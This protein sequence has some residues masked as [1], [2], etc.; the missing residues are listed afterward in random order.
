MFISKGTHVCPCVTK[1]VESMYQMDD[2]LSI[3]CLYK[4]MYFFNGCTNS[5]LVYLPK[6]F[7]CF[8]LKN[9]QNLYIL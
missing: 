5:G 8:K 7:A 6:I 2:F 9:S 3:L 4:Y 1:S